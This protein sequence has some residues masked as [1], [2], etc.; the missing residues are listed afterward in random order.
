MLVAFNKL[1]LPA[2]RRGV[3]RRS[4]TRAPRRGP[5]PSRSRRRAGRGSTPSARAIADLLPERR[6]ARRAARAGRRRRPPD[7]G[8][9]RRVRR[10]ARRGRRVPG[11]RQADRADRRPDELR[12][13][14]IGR[15][16]P[17]RPG[18]PRDRRRAAPGRRSAP[19]TSS[20]SVR[21]SSNGS[22]SLGACGDAA[23]VRPARCARHLRRHV[24]PDP[25]RASGRRR[26]GPRLAR[27]RRV[28]F[29]PAG[30]PP[31][32]LDRPITPRRAPPG[33]GRGGDRG[34]SARSRSSRIE[35]D[36]DGPSYTVD[37]LRARS[38]RT[39]RLGD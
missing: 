33:D 20:G 29:V 18:A 8:D 15:A 36:R 37:T 31:H 4:A 30:E 5:R 16:V 34:Q 32:K 39:A 3:A 2:A 1:D 27:P 12:G 35:L 10:R 9:G 38:T 19:A 7:R 14:G 17:A 26:G 21:P 23:S 25:H 6:R 11:A 24:R 28:L 13:R 22:R